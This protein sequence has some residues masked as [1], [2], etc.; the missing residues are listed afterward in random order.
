VRPPTKRKAGAEGQP[1]FQNSKDGSNNN[2]LP[3]VAQV[4]TLRPWV[5]C[6]WNKPRTRYKIIGGPYASERQAYDA[7]FG[8]ELDGF[9]ADV[10]RINE[11]P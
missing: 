11:L 7:R 5:L 10:E 8:A 3:H 9:Y 1:A 6:L 2:A 4:V